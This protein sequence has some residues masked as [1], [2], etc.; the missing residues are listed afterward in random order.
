MNTFDDNKGKLTIEQQIQLRK[1]A[2]HLRDLAQATDYEP[3]NPKISDLLNI[4][5]DISE[6]QIKLNTYY[7][8][9]E[10]PEHKEEKPNE[11]SEEP[12]KPSIA[13]E[14]TRW[15]SQGMPERE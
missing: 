15:F 11:E 7:F 9:H 1:L 6:E 13:D 14:I 3:F 10:C 5:A 8:Y 4:I 12:E 2:N